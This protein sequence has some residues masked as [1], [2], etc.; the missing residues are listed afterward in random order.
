VGVLVE[1]ICE[2]ILCSS[3]W[4]FIK[5][6]SNGIKALMECQVDRLPHRQA[7]TMGPSLRGC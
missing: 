1:K 7:Q 3:R 5:S 2:G 4:E 6:N